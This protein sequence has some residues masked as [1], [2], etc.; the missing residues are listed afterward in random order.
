MS[1][2]KKVFLALVTVLSTLGVAC[3]SDDTET[4]A[5]RTPRAQPSAEATEAPE[6]TEAAPSHQGHKS[7]TRVQIIDT[8]Y[9]KP[10]V[11]IDAGSKVKW[12]QIGDQPHSVSAADGS[13]DSSPNVDR[14]NRI[15]ALGWT[16]SSITSSI[17]LGRTSTT[18]GCTGFPT[19]PGWSERS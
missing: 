10:T 6:A 14:S 9:R 16:T 4:A 17:S 1:A 2:K 3:G 7:A 5:Q 15:C 8:D 19:V 12:T 13:F 11:T 18:A